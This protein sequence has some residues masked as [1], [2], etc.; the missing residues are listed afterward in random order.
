MTDK[1]QNSVLFFTVA[2]AAEDSTGSTL[3]QAE[4]KKFIFLGHQDP[5]LTRSMLVV[6]I[7]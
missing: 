7:I 4:L 6:Y 1:T 2:I 3:C 5:Q